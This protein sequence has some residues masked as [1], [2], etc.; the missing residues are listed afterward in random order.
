MILWVN[1]HRNAVPRHLDTYRVLTVFGLLTAL[2]TTGCGGISQSPNQRSSNASL[3]SGSK[4]SILTVST[5]I[6]PDAIQSESYKAQIIAI[7]GTPPY[8]WKLTPGQTSLPAG[9]SL[10]SSG[11]LS[12]NPLGSG[13]FQLGVTVADAV[14]NVAFMVLNLRIQ[15]NLTITTTTLPA[16]SANQPYSIL[17]NANGGTPPYTWAL[18]PGT[19][20]LPAG[21]SVL[22]SG[23]VVGKT[24]QVETVNT[25]VAVHDS[26]LPASHSAFQMLTLVV[27][28]PDDNHNETIKISTRQLPMAK[29]A[30]PYEVALNAT[31]GV[32]PYSWRLVQNSPTLPTGV[33][34]ESIGTL[35][36]LPT[37]PGQF[38][39]TVE[40]ADAANTIATGLFNLT[41][42]SHSGNTYYVDSSGG[43]D[44][45]DGL[46]PESAWATLT[47]ITKDTFSPGDQILLRRDSVWREQLEMP[48]SGE[49]GNPIVISTFGNGNPPVI[50]G[51]D[52]IHNW[53]LFQGSVYQAQIPWAPHHIWQDGLL[54]QQATTLSGVNSPGHWF[55]DVSNRMVDVW[56]LGGVSPV[57]HVFEADRRN[58]AVDFA[59]KSYV[60]LEGLALKNSTSQLIGV[61]NSAGISVLNCQLR[62]AQEVAVDVSVASPGFL[63]DHSTYEV[64]PGFTGRGFVSVHSTAADGPIVSNNSVGNFRG[65]I[66]VVFDDVNNPQI[67][68]NTITGNGIGIAFNGT[69]RNVTGLDA[70][71]N[72]I[73]DCDSRF[74]DGE[75]IEFTGHKVPLFTAGGRAY[76]NYVKGGP[77][78]FGGIDGW[79][80]T[81]SDI[82]GNIVVGMSHWGMEWTAASTGNRF[83]N[84]T[85]Y[86]S[87]VGGMAFYYSS[88][89][90]QNN[91]LAHIKQVDISCQGGTVSEDYNL[92]DPAVPQRSIGIAAGEHTI[93][94]DPMF[95]SQSPV[96]ALDFRLTPGSPAVGS[97]VPLAQP[98]DELFDPDAVD[99]PLSV[100]QLDS[101][102]R[103]F[104]RGAFGY[105]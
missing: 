21:L 53:K 29:I 60:T 97:G 66:A 87:G 54:L 55:Y 61:W 100:M 56:P 93:A 67:F 99:F 22:S 10:D 9:L 91:I 37:Q 82:Y 79:H 62:N 24:D 4:T 58:R 13:S 30:Q 105:R 76:R 44:A 7:G 52:L 6:L 77:Y 25:V 2:M 23:V 5:Q 38:A 19:T 42:L 35:A 65:P 26:S 80:A 32:P 28:P 75:C 48:S 43:N 96:D 95:V 15:T 64:D 33:S 34:L 11:R 63:I 20:P 90:V 16:V 8:V 72:V 83:Y 98:Y 70:H 73:S 36:G 41:V 92:V 18:A 81:N 104:D 40:V 101:Q 88:A 31:G 12:G 57:A 103:K 46:T 3:S 17:L 50:N 94:A 45:N 69:T 59:R 1:S 74:G 39:F 86:D 85:I 68:G 102:V 89:V 27:N 51:A 49:P 78:S 14:H 84:N 71:D 47:R